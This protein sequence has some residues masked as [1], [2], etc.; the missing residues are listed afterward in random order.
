MFDVQK[1]SE[2]LQKISDSYGSIS[3]FAEK[4]EVNRTYISKYI[5]M[6]L[7]SPPTPKILE[8]IS[9]QLFLVLEIPQLELLFLMVLLKTWKIILATKMEIKNK[10]KR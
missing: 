9:S 5:N 8:K 2:I 4:S 6:K 10:S 3:E 1:F 7:D